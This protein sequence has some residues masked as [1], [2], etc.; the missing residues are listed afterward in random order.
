MVFE[1][2]VDLNGVVINLS[3]GLF[4]R[5]LKINL[6]IAEHWSKQGLS[7]PARDPFPARLSWQSLLTTENKSSALMSCH[8]N[9]GLSPTSYKAYVLQFLV[10]A[11]QQFSFSLLQLF[12][13]PASPH[14]SA[15]C[16][17]HHILYCWSELLLLFMPSDSVHAVLWCLSWWWDW[18]YPTCQV[19]PCLLTNV[20]SSC[21]GAAT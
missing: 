11:D 14:Y 8:K 12:K 9:K 2:Y 4:N 17:S 16:C 5:A 10:E 20:S 6:N 15:F 13:I 21:L 18:L 3:F 1:Y 19:S 7:T